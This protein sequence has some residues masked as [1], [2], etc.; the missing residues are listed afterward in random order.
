AIV[1]QC[2]QTRW[3]PCAMKRVRPSCAT[4]VETAWQRIRVSE[5][6]DVHSIR[7][8]SIWSRI[9]SDNRHC[10]VELSCTRFIDGTGVGL[11]VHLHKRLVRDGRHL[12]LL[13]PSAPVRR[14]LKLMR[15]ED[16]FEI[17]SDAVEARA[18]IERRGLERTT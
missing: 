15:L 11:L 12:I 17:V 13:S 8:D 18:I 6:F 10:L 2:W 7:R 4:V 3:R 9:P 5:R 14:L 16:C 1:T